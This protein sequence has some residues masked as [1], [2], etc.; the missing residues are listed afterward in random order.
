MADPRHVPDTLF[1]VAEED[2]RLF[3]R[4]S[5][6]QPESLAQIAESAYAA[7]ST[8][9]LA[10]PGLSEGVNEPVALPL[11]DMYQWHYEREPLSSEGAQHLFGPP[12]AGTESWKKL[13][14]GLYT[15]TRKPTADEVRYHGVSEY[16]EDLV[17]MCTAA[18]RAGVG[19]LVW[20]SWDGFDRKGHKNRVGHAATLIAVSATGAKKLADIVPDTEVFGRPAHFDL[21]LLRYMAKHGN[22]F[23]ASYVF[24]C[25]GHYQANLSQSSDHEGWRN[26]QWLTSWVQEGVAE[27]PVIKHKCPHIIGV[28][29]C[30]HIVTFHRG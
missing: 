15:P 3:A 22:E 2:F 13:I 1:F 23:G 12:A 17:K 6:V 30:L 25:V 26:S 7:S 21:L 10:R 14:G 27:Q 20:L 4:H 5:S 19:N 29:Q 16:L 11:S 8:A 9:H 24:P 18:Q 28:V